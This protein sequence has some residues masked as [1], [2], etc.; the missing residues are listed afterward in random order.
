[1]RRTNRIALALSL[2][3]P[4][5]LMWGCGGD[6]GGGGNGTG[7]APVAT[8]IAAVS[9]GGQT[10]PSGAQLPAPF[11]VRVTDDQGGGFSGATVS[12]SVTSGG[13]SLSATSTQT[14]TQGQAS[15][16]LTLGPATGQN[17][18]TASATGLAGSPVTFTATGTAPP[19]PDA[20]A[21]VS[22]DN[23]NG[24]TLE[25][26][27]SPF[28]VKVTDDQGGGVAGVTVNWAVASGGG[29]VS[30]P[31]TTTN[32]S[33]E[34]SVRFSSGTATGASTVTASAP[35]LTGSPITFSARTSVLVIEMDGIRFV[36]PD[37]ST[38]SGATVAVGD[39]VEWVNREGVQ[40]TATSNVE[41][42]GGASFNSGLLTN[43]QTFR[44]APSVVGTWEYFCEV[45]PSLMAGA[46]IT[47]Q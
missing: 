6:D 47:V 36:Y 16:T 42:A 18:V 5:L 1:M 9:G 39:T 21:L 20:I 26:L 27:A 4:A 7:P 37:G 12:W 35:G 32:G 43:G 38:N 3:T 28:V 30:A 19:Q 22:G 40:H 45:H 2:A 29:S 33:G 46:T 23:Q 10:A 24:K 14:N 17:T 41:P 8:T 31:S 34:A 13:G 15:V 11:V 44:F 25:P